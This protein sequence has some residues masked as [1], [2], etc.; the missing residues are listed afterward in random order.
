MGDE[1]VEAGGGAAMLMTT[2]LEFA[3]PAAAAG[4]DLP[5]QLDP[6]KEGR[7]RKAQER[8]EAQRR[9]DAV[10]QVRELPKRDATRQHTSF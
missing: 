6:W 10:Y 1:M 5:D 9:V 4:F 2:R 8:L 7:A 3:S